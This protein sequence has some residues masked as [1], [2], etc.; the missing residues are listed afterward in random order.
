MKAFFHIPTEE[1]T[2]VYSEKLCFGMADD[3][4][5]TQAENNGLFASFRDMGNV[6]ATFVGHG[7]ILKM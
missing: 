5:D 6:R 1:Y 4:I 2:G 7:N 3:G